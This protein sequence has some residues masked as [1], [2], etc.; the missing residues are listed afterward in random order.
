MKQGELCQN[1]STGTFLKVESEKLSKSSSRAIERH[2]GWIQTL[3]N[4]PF[5]STALT[6]IFAILDGEDISRLIS[7][8]ESQSE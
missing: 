8:R 4:V 5:G 1:D 7:K 2:V 3:P 6:K